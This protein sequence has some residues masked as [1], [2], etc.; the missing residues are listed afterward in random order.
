MPS[1]TPEKEEQRHTCSILVPHA[2]R[3]VSYDTNRTEERAWL[4]CR[5]SIYEEEMGR[6]QDA[7]QHAIESYEDSLVFHGGSLYTKVLATSLRSLGRF[8]EARKLEKQWGREIKSES[9]IKELERDKQTEHEIVQ[10]LLSNNRY[11][12]AIRGI[13][14]TYTSHKA[15]SYHKGMLD[16]LDKIEEIARQ[17]GILEE[18][19]SL[20]T[21]AVKE[22]IEIFGDNHSITF[23]YME[24]LGRALQ[25]QGKNAEAAHLFRSVLAGRQKIYGIEHPSV[26]ET[27]DELSVALREEGNLR[28]AEEL[29]K[30]VLEYTQQTL[31]L[32]HCRTWRAVR[33]LSTTLKQSG[34]LRE[35]IAVH[36][37]ILENFEAASEE[38]IKDPDNKPFANRFLVDTENMLYEALELS[39]SDFGD[40]LL[41]R[42]NL[43]DCLVLQNKWEVAEEN[44]RRILMAY[45][46]RAEFQLGKT[47]FHHDLASILYMQKKF[48]AALTIVQNNLEN[49]RTNYPEDTSRIK[50]AEEIYTDIM[51]RINEQSDEQSAERVRAS[52]RSSEMSAKATRELLV[53][54]LFGDLSE[55]IRKRT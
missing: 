26:M 30:Q 8:S 53:A 9:N 6:Y 21:Q 11:D 31:G 24:I 32:R 46:Q 15:R 39:Q 37:I 28:Q 45:E 17:N 14:R 13:Y 12:E 1:F 33:E 36:I 5:M 22:S 43:A 38:M 52:N 42:G 20:F 10:E 23:N 40:E 35:A 41:L 54:P 19:E 18:I 51:S 2:T 44:V 29:G 3:V 47:D 50:R 49:L 7:Y 16:S 4:L 27:I 55:N 25:G 34:K 48:Q